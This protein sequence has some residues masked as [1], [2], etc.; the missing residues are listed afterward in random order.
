ME[1]VVIPHVLNVVLTYGHFGEQLFLYCRSKWEKC[2]C[3][4]QMIESQ[5]KDEITNW[6]NHLGHP[7]R[8]GKPL[9]LSLPTDA[10]AGFYLLPGSHHCALCCIMATLDTLPPQ[11]FPH[12]SGLRADPFI[13]LL[14]LFS[15]QLYRLG[16]THV[17]LNP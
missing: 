12:P 1:Q 4:L 2:N 15:A 3:L 11:I 6:A 14:L 16:S 5:V 7:C 17:G 13:Q 10:G 8:L 9:Q